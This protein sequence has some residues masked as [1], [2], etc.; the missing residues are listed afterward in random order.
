MTPTYPVIKT[1]PRILNRH[2]AYL[3]NRAPCVGCNGIHISA[4][5][6]AFGCPDLGFNQP[7]RLRTRPSRLRA[8]P[9]V[10]HVMNSLRNRIKHELQELIPVTLFFFRAFQLLALTQRLMLKEYGIH[11]P[12]FIA[13][14]VGALIVAKVVIIVDCFPWV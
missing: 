2:R 6:K 11:V 3:G 7:Q 8:R 14:T 10:E 1:K 4:N 13:A 9:W 12:T 5:Q